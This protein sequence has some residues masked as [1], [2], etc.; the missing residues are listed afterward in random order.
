MRTLHLARK[1]WRKSSQWFVLSR[2][3]A[4]VVANDQE[5]ATVFEVECFSYLPDTDLDVPPHVQVLPSQPFLLHP[6]IVKL[7]PSDRILD[8]SLPALPPL[9][10]SSCV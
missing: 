7:L 2:L 4:A 10:I 6:Q 9:P 3:L 1:H 8:C 5:A